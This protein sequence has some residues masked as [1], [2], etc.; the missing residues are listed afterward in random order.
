MRINQ[1][2]E[3]CQTF[4]NFLSAQPRLILIYLPALGAGFQ[5]GQLRDLADLRGTS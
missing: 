5:G 2:E 1:M 3:V 4:L